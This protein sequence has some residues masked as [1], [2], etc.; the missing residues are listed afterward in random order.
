[1]TIA[2]VKFASES[3]IKIITHIVAFKIDIPYNVA[4]KKPVNILADKHANLYDAPSIAKRYSHFRPDIRYR[5]RRRCCFLCGRGKLY[6]LQQHATGKRIENA[7]K[8]ETGL[9]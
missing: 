9:L 4:Y 6:A 3:P 2:F 1:M 5:A 8:T 7:S